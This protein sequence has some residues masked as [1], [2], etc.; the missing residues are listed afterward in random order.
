MNK[1]YDALEEKSNH[2]VSVNMVIQELYQVKKI[3]NFFIE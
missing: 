2:N 3:L 1:K